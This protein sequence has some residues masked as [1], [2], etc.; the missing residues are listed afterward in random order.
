MQYAVLVRVSMS[1]T[2][3]AT[4][5]L[6]EQIVPGISQAQ[7][8]VGGYWTL[9]DDGSTGRS[10]II[11]ESEDAARAAKELI[12]PPPDGS[13]AIENLDIGEVIATA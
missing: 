5:F 10:M 1:D 12:Q 13:A 3:A 4:R 11:F 6:H 8:F 2:E 7:G 9:S